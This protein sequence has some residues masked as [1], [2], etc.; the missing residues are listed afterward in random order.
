M[1]PASGGL[2]QGIRS[3]TPALEALGIYSEVVSLDAPDAEFIGADPFPLHALG[4]GHTSWRYNRRLGP[5][6]RRHLRNFDAAI[7]EGLWLHPGL[8]LWHAARKTHTPYFVFPHGMLDPWFQNDP[9]R[10]RKSVRNRLYWDLIE[11]RIIRD[12]NALLF[13]CEA[14]MKLARQ[15]FSPYSPQGEIVVGYGTAAPPIQTAAMQEAFYAHCVNLPRGIP[16]LLFLGRIHPKKGVDLLIKAF[17]Q[18]SLEHREHPSGWPALVI[19]GPGLETDYGFE[20]QQLARTFA[21]ASSILF[22]GMLQGEAKWGAFYGCEAF[23]LP[24]HQEN[25]GIAVV[26]ALACGKPVMIT[27]QVNIWREVERCGA[28]VVEEDS[29]AG[30]RRA[31]DRW[32]SERRSSEEMSGNAIRC[33]ERHFTVESAALKLR[34]AI[35]PD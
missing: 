14:E 2:S 9:S 17:G 13:T 22:T 3:T 16:Y 20:M 23:V 27:H 8:A 32:M 18:L 6:L 30:V 1:D 11:H 31:L 19:A 10:R 24:S 35:V 29:I 33:Y 5:W 12:A 21:D 25:F 4:E 15:P 28:G 26:E 7:L 34:S